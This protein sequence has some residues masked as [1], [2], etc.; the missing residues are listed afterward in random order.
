VIKIDVPG[1]RIDLVVD[2]DVL[3]ERRR[4]WKAPPPRYS[5]GALA[6]YAKLVGSAESGAICE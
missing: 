3:E 5:T 6:K 1:R 4:D 2:D